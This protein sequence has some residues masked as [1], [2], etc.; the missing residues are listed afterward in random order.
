MGEIIIMSKFYQIGEVL[1]NG[2][3]E[4]GASSQ[5]MIYKS[6]EA[7][8]NKT[9][10]C[11]VPELDDTEYTYMDFYNL[12]NGNEEIA[13]VLFDMVDWQ[14][15]ETKKNELLENDEIH[16][17]INCENMYDSY[18]AD[19]CPHCGQLKVIDSFNDE[20]SEIFIFTVNNNEYKVTVN[21]D[22]MK[23]MDWSW[24]SL[25]FANNID[26]FAVVE[27]TANQ[28]S[29]VLNTNGEV[30]VLDLVN[31]TE[32]SKE[33][34]IK[35]SLSK[36]LDNPEKYSIESNNWFGVDYIK[37]GLLEEDIVFESTPITALGV[38]NEMIEFHLNYFDK[39]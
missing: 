25:I 24:D 34:I 29:S 19:K 9:G 1:E 16:I 22:L 33:E 26:T 11:Y 35:L 20:K 18:G 15:P 37:G 17:C 36:E 31:N 10:V 8:I 5:G 23:K 14:S 2:Q 7:F 4:K 12:A 38:A 21:T 3:I 6:L 30:K 39:K 32:L 28:E 27:N 13:R